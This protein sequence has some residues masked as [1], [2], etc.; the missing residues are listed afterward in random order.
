MNIVG[1]LILRLHPGVSRNRIKIS[2]DQIRKN[3]TDD[4]HASNCCH[5]LPDLPVFSGEKVTGK[6]HQT[7]SIERLSQMVQVFLVI[8]RL[9]P[10]K[11]I[12]LFHCPLSQTFPICE[13]RLCLHCFYSNQS[14]ER[15]GVGAEAQ[16]TCGNVRKTT[17]Q[18]G[19]DILT[20][21]FFLQKQ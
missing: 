21:T 11:P 19:L 6:N 8:K 4:T 7:P 20:Q 3:P 1:I 14:V 12:N 18:T 16:D 10:T 9:K 5:K 2:S 13:F 15:L 17:L